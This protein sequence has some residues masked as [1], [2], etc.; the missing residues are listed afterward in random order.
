MFVVKIQGGLGNQ[1]FQYN[2]A[3]FLKKR[4]P[5][6]DIRLNTNFFKEDSI[7]GGF[8][9]EKVAFKICNNLGLRSFKVIRDATFDEG[10]INAGQNLLFDGYWQ[11]TKFFKEP[12]L[13]FF[14]FFDDKMPQCDKEY[15]DLISEAKK[16]V[17]V[18]VRCGDYNNHFLLGNIATKS[19]YN[20]AVKEYIARLKKPVFFVFSDDIEWAKANIDFGK[21]QVHYIKGNEKPSDNKWDIYLMSL[22]KHNIMSNSSFSWWGHR[23]GGSQK[24]DAVT[25]EYWTN[26]VGGDFP[27]ICLQNEK[28]MSFVPN[29]PLFSK[30]AAKKPFFSIII[31]S[32]NQLGCLRRAIS[33]ALNQ[34]FEDFEVI[35]V[36]D[37]S[38]DGTKE[39]LK[40]LSKKNHKLKPVIHSK[41][42]SSLMARKSG[43]KVAAG[44]YI[45]LLDG[46]DYLFL[47]ALE[48]LYDL[49]QKKDF[50]ALEF[51]YISRPKN[52]VFP[53][54]KYDS[55]MDRLEYQSTDNPVVTI[56]N[57]LYKAEVVKMAFGKLPDLYVN[58]TDDTLMSIY[59]SPYIKSF[60]Q[61]D[62]LITNYRLQIGVS[63]K[64]NTLTGVLGKL[65]SVK[66][67]CDGIVLFFEKNPVERK[68]EFSFSICKR[69]YLYV[70]NSAND[71]DSA[72]DVKKVYLSLKA[73]FA[74]KL[75][76]YNFDS[77][78]LRFM[79]KWRVK[80][81]ARFF[82]TPKV[83]A[84]I[85]TLLRKNG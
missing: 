32:F 61:K 83:K 65:N 53:P 14:D 74:D 59:I 39:F 45:I 1:L 81:A 84:F 35:V 50:D 10:N 47:D 54:V 16:S 85:K 21:G 52:E 48:K 22:C 76:G 20:N 70:L 57:K 72:K 15:C 42:M 58:A 44:K 30:P 31:T 63:N 19:Y 36:D 33:S 73:Y 66:N 56:W 75:P 3:L 24:R 77:E 4:Y 7:H 69:L 46:D 41:N 64:K 71:L 13:N 43:A 51:S 9:L 82:L 38:T 12:S 8:M 40:A 18:H 11:D 79:A 60:I 23:F 49:A 34:T 78:Y 2:F 67:C 37:A 6:A 80:K 25:P 5:D 28:G 68:T 55:K 27:D 62:L 29:Y 26:E 17:S